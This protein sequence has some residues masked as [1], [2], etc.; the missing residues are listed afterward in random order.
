MTRE[1]KIVGIG[2]GSGVLAMVI[3]MTA[4]ILL[5]PAPAGLDTLA[6]RLAYTLRIDAVAALPLLV[7]IITVGNNRFQSDAIDPMRRKEDMVTM[8]NG[9]VVEN[10]LQQYVLFLIGTLALGAT[11][12]AERMAVVPV[13]ATVFVLSRVAF[14]IGYRMDPLYRAFGM[15]STGYL[16]L[17]LLSYVAWSVLFQPL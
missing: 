3:A 8:I 14:W 17:G 6:E 11:L 5:V 9:Q 15:A 12:E 7:A 16:N 10:T 13:A 4:G 1:Q 2:A